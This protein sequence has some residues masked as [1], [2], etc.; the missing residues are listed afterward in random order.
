MKSAS[1]MPSTLTEAVLRNASNYG[2]TTSSGFGG[3][4][5]NP[6]WTQWVSGTTVNPAPGV[7]PTPAPVYNI[8]VIIVVGKDAHRLHDSDELRESVI[9]AVEEA[10][11]VGRDHDTLEQLAK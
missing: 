7:P 11:Q 8:N 4:T 9:K 6:P 10:M 3:Y 5:P 2:M 1:T